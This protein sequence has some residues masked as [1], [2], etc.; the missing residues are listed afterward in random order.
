MAVGARVGRGVE[1]D[2]VVIARLLCVIDNQES[3]LCR[4][5]IIGEQVI[6]GFMIKVFRSTIIVGFINVEPCA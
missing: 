5:L 4:L 1:S 6:L 2:L 3:G